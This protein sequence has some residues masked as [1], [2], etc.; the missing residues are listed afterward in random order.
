MKIIVTLAYAVLLW[1]CRSE[2]ILD[3][4]MERYSFSSWSGTTNVFYTALVEP[5]EID[6]AAFP[7]NVLCVSPEY[8]D[9]GDRRER[10]MLVFSEPDDLL[11]ARVWMGFATNVVM[12]QTELMRMFS[13]FTMS[14]MLTATNG[15]AGDRCYYRTST[16]GFCCVDFTRNNVVVDVAVYTNCLYAFDIARQLDAAIL[17]VSTN[18]P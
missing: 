1:S 3:F 5:M 9:S 10:E 16:N 4:T 17:N 11:L 8:G 12:A 13:E 15:L 14:A 7:T 2:Q 6:T 18:T